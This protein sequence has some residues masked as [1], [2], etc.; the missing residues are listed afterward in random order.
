M[1]WWISSFPRVF[2]VT[3]IRT[4][5]VRRVL[6]CAR[7]YTN[8]CGA[9]AAA[10]ELRG[11]R[12]VG[13]A[14]SGH[15]DRHL[16]HAVGDDQLHDPRRAGDVH[17]LGFRSAD[18]SVV[19]NHDGTYTAQIT[20]STKAGSSTITATDTATGVHGDATLVE[21]PGP[22]ESVRVTL[23][24]TAILADGKST[25]GA[26]ATVSDANGNNEPSGDSVSFASTDSGEKIGPVT[27]NGNGTYTATITA[28]TRPGK[29]TI[30]ATDLTDK[31]SGQAT[32]T[33]RPVASKIAVTL[34]PM[35]IP[36]DGVSRATATASVTDSAGGPVPGD[37]VSFASTDSGERIGPVTDN[38]GGTYTVMITAS[39]TVGT[40]T[41]TATDA[42]PSPSING[43]GALIQTQIQATPP[44]LSDVKFVPSKLK[45]KHGAKLKLTLS[46]PS[47]VTV[48]V[49]RTV[50]GRISR[51][52]CDAH[53]KHGKRC[54]SHVKKAVLTLH[55]HN[56]PNTFTFR[57]SRL[58]PGHYTATVTAFGATGL[59]SNKIT[60]RFTVK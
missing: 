40:A 11:W 25:T 50:R 28:S 56:G 30:T 15:L 12:D 60:V 13:A 46:A 21:T 37:K 3:L 19:D 39:H 20:A 10:L 29:A 55:G 34:V 7:A 58:R 31:L 1:W 17:E 33:Q 57:S 59:A 35:S 38:G 44:R 54:T 23:A 51:G 41:I 16:G 43:H 53:A 52:R 48:V 6:W 18:R 9:A 36:A 5:V 14:R 24:P 49:K 27:D 32:L 47:S 22:A 2:G 42:S 45:R 8:L 26:T 4:V